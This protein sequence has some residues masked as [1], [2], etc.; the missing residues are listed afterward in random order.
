MLGKRRAD[1][2]NLISF[3][4]LRDGVVAFEDALDAERYGSYLE[5]DGHPAVSIACCDS[6]KL[7]RAVQDVHAVVVYLRRQ[8]EASLPLPDQLATSLRG[9]KSL[10]EAF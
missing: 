8:P 1:G 3:Q 7:F 5:A 4:T 2:S 9:K 6:H 10:E